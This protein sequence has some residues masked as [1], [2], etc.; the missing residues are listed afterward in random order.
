MQYGY[1]SESKANTV[2][3]FFSALGSVAFAYGGH[4][5]VMEVQ[6]TMPSTQEK[7]SK[8]PMWKG[9]IFVYVIIGLCYIPVAIIGYRMFGNKV[10]ENI[11]V[12]LH[13]PKWFVAMANMFVMVHLVGGYQVYLNFIGLIHLT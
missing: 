11:L 8:K 7:P 3:D 6:A 13:K 1:R 9:V 5:V 10:N 12:S 2:F 4:N